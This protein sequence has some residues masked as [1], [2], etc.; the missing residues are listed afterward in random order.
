MTK[1]LPITDSKFICMEHITSDVTTYLSQDILL[2]QEQVLS[3]HN[4]IKNSE[5]PIL[6]DVSIKNSKIIVSSKERMKSA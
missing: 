5:S 2:N 4:Q 1:Y 6:G 3:L